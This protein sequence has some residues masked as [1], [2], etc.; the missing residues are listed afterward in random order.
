MKC[1]ILRIPLLLL[2]WNLLMIMPL[3]ALPSDGLSVPSG[4]DPAQE[5]LKPIEEF[6]G[7]KTVG[8]MTGSLGEILLTEQ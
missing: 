6:L 2:A 3:P 7:N 4:Q 8:V 5:G 1:S